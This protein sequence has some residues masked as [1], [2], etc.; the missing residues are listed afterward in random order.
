MHL[1]LT[2]RQSMK[3]AVKNVGSYYVGRRKTRARRAA[4]DYLAALEQSLGQ[5][6]SIVSVGEEHLG[7]AASSNLSLILSC[8]AV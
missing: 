3:K 2:R 8:G 6:H 1:Q 4:S 5:V 7:G